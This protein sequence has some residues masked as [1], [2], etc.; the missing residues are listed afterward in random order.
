MARLLIPA[1]Y[2]EREPALR[3]L[4]QARRINDTIYIRWRPPRTRRERARW[5]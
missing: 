4:V 3:R 1:I 5:R 2:L